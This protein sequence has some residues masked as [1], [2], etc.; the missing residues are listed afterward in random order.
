MTATL[1]W[2][3]VAEGAASDARGALTLVGFNAQVFTQEQYPVAM[4]PTFIAIMEGGPGEERFVQ[5]LQPSVQISVEDESGRTVFLVD[6]PRQ[7]LG[8]KDWWMLP[9]RLQVVMQVNFLAEFPGRYTAT[10]RMNLW[11]GDALAHADSRSVNFWIL[12]SAAREEPQVS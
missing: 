3:G 8:P 1:T 5:D 9:D 6:S 12:P 7:P 2:V 11:R 10:V 4:S